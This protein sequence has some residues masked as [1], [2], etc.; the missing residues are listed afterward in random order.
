MPN[1]DPRL[2][3]LDKDLVCAVLV[4]IVDEGNLRHIADEDNPSKIWD[5]LTCAHQ[6]ASTGGCVFC[7]WKLLNAQMD[8]DNINSHIDSLAKFHKLLNSLSTP[9]DIHNVALLS[10]IPP[11][12]IHC[13]SN[14]MNQ[15]GVK[16]DTI[17]KALHNKAVR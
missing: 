2:G 11:D 3:T 15:E 17:V 13:V 6:D 7:I 1:F 5:D 12:W 14:L 9:D 8:R 10:S 4:Q 16:T